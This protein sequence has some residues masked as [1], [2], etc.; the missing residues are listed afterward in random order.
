MADPVTFE[1]ILASGTAT[2]WRGNVF[3]VMLNDFPPDRENTRGARWN[4]PETPAIYTCL[5]PSVCI[6]EVE[7]GLSRQ[8]TPVKPD[9]RKT[10]YEISVSL[11]AVLD[12]TEV[13]FSLGGIGIDLSHLHADDMKISQEIGR[14]V[15]WFGYDGLL[16]PSARGIGNNLVIYPG[17]AREGYRFEVI[18]HS[19]L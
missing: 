6:A 18:G 15:T 9:L 17:R 11:S 16:V 13:L 4:P 7:Y 2:P 5:E 1:S 3:R 14:L 19:A 10:L 12:I 8:P